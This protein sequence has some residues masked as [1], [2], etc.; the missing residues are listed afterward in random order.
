MPTPFR[1]LI[2][3]ILLAVLPAGAQEVQRHGLVFETWVRD[4]FFDGYHPRFHTQKWDIPAA[5]NVRFGG[6]PV[7][8]KAIKPL[9]HHPAAATGLTAAGIRQMTSPR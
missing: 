3:A 7:N 5:V 8:P 4:T 9:G 6:V 2:L 1:L